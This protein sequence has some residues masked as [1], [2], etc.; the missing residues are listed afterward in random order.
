IEVQKQFRREFQ[1]DPPTR[2]TI[3]QIRDQFQADGTVQ[4]VYKKL[5]ERPWTST[6]FTIQEML[7]ETYC[8]IS[9]KSVRQV[10]CVIEIL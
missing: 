10:S 3:T 9:K 4:N 2:L 1:T 6:N 5:Y 7:M 8:Q